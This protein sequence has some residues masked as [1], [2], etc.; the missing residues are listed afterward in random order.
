M[1]ASLW[2]ATAISEPYDDLVNHSRTD[3]VEFGC[4]SNSILS[5]TVQKSGGTAA[6][7][8]PASGYDLYTTRDTDRA[9]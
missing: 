2:S 5:D 3:F 9:C 8:C 7:F 4:S 1:A 6:R